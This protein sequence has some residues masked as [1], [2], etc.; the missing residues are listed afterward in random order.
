MRVKFLG[1]LG[2]TDATALKL[3]WRECQSGLE[4]ELPAEVFSV[5]SRRYPALVQDVTPAPA[6]VE[7]VAQKPTVA[8]TKDVPLMKGNSK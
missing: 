7:G 5:L 8:E 6:K 4:V 3:D 2:I 1:N